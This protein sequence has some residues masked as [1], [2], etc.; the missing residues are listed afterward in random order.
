VLWEGV[1]WGGTSQRIV[2]YGSWRYKG[3]SGATAS[4]LSWVWQSRRAYLALYV[5]GAEGGTSLARLYAPR[6]GQGQSREL[7]PVVRAAD[8]DR[9]VREMVGKAGPGDFRF[10]T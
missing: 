4:G 6:L 8:V 5:N 1:F 10:V 3:R 7:Q 2:G 9:R